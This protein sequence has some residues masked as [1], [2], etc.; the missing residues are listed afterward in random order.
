MEFIKKSCKRELL[1]S[2]LIGALLPLVLCCAFLIQLFKAKLA[3]ILRTSISRDQIITL[4]EEM[5]LVENYAE[6]QRIRFHGKFRFEYVL[7]EELR[8]CIIPKLIVQPIVENSVIHG[9]AECEEGTIRAEVSDREG[10]LTI[11]VT[12]DGCGISPEVLERLNSRDREKLTGHIGFYNVDEEHFV[13]KGIVLE[14]DW[15]APGCG[16]VAEAENGYEALEAVHRYRPDLI[17]S[18]SRMTRFCRFS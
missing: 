6:I 2:F 16:V 13:R 8:T 1:A 17:I 3:K 9:L 4:Q 11:E 18:D 7:P 12:D 14:T 15:S 10:I 5:E